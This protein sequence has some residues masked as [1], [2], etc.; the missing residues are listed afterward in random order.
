METGASLNSIVF[1][2]VASSENELAPKGVVRRSLRLPRVT[3]CLWPSM[4]RAHDFAPLA[5]TKGSE[6][7]SAED[8]LIEADIAFPVRRTPRAVN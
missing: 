3:I 4:V 1:R 6:S 2:V 8:L 5:D 7:A